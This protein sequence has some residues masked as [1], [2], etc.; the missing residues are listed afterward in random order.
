M[1]L[2]GIKV[3]S[4]SLL[5]VGYTTNIRVKE[6]SNCLLVVNVKIKVNGDRQK[7][8]KFKVKQAKHESPQRKVDAVPM[9]F[10]FLCLFLC[11]VIRASSI[12]IGLNWLFPPSSPLR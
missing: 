10:L 9:Y 8:K 2:V 7:K 4:S 5:R 1:V 11:A 12:D 6:L 3:G